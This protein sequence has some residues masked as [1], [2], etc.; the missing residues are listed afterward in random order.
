MYTHHRENPIRYVKG[1]KPNASSQDGM[2]RSRNNADSVEADKAGTVKRKHQE[3]SY[4]G[5]NRAQV[6]FRA[7]FE[8]KLSLPKPARERKHTADRKKELNKEDFRK[9]SV[10]RPH[11][12]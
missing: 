1:K 8:F 7:A 6:T 5:A 12:K 10:P 9:S 11:Y 2:L 4:K 3:K